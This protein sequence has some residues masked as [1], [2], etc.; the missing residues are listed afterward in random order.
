M[1]PNTKKRMPAQPSTRGVVWLCIVAMVLASLAMFLF[2]NREVL[3]SS[4]F[5]SATPLSNVSASAS[6]GSGG[7]YVISEEK[8]RIEAFDAEGRRLFQI[9][10]DPQSGAAPSI[11]TELA[12]DGEGRLY[13]LDTQLDE[14]GLY[15]ISEHIL[16]Y[17]K[18]GKLER[19]LFEWKGDRKSKRIGQIKALQVNGDELSFF[20]SGTS[21]VE[22]KRMML[23]TGKWDQPFAF[24]LPPDRYISEIAGHEPGQIY[25]AT[26]RGAIYRVG[27]DGQSTKLY[28]TTVMSSTRKNF[29]ERLKLGERDSVTFI[30]R[31][32]NTVTRLR[33]SAHQPLETLA[34]AEISAAGELADY[35]I[36][37]QAGIYVLA[38]RLVEAT[39][40]GDPVR[41]V[42]QIKFNGQ[43]RLHHW[44]VWAAA[45]AAVA[46]V[47]LALRLTYVHVMRRRISFFLK[48]MVAFVPLIAIS[49]VLLSN[50][51]YQSFSAKM[52]EEMQREL[53]VLAQSGKYIIDGDQLE[54]LT[55]PND[56]MNY[57]YLQI[58][59][60]MNILFEGENSENRRGLYSTVYKYEDGKL[61]I[62]TDDNDGINMFKPYELTPENLAVLEQ[63]QIRSNSTD[64]AE[65]QWTYALAPIYNSE[66]TVVGIFETG[67]DRNVLNQENGRIF[68]SVIRQ[69]ILITFLILLVFVVSSYFLLASLRKLRRSV[70]E[71][72]NGNWDVEVSIRSR[73]EVADLGEQ[74]NLM[75]RHIRQYIRDITDFSEASYRFV[76]QQVIKYLGKRGIL[77]VHLGDQVQQNMVVMVAKIRS[78]YDMTKRLTPKENFNFMNSFLS[79]FGPL[80][81][82]EEGLISSYL[83]AGFMSLF[84]SRTEDAIQ[85]AIAIR[86]ELI[87]YNGHRRKSGYPPVDLG[88]AIHKGA[89]MMGIIGEESR[90]ES[91]VISD[92]V[93]LTT[94]LE[95]ASEQL[96]ASILI[97]RTALETM[98]APERFQYRWLG[99]I[100][101]DSKELPLELYDIYEGDEETARLGKDKTKALFERGVALYQEGRFFDARETFVEVI[102]WNRQ[103]KAAKLYFYLCDEYYQQGTAADWNGTLAVS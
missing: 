100:Q 39:A 88:I 12:V 3:Q 46:L 64:D 78:F 82:K 87:V 47:A 8:Q 71:I 13:V 49:M 73:D 86:K 53:S 77:D 45:V 21:G 101:L 67:R 48:Q 74:F 59:E 5:Q 26:R 23:S 17:T 99:R 40:A 4:P 19:Q 22:Q 18:D 20:I 90:M 28:P 70:T 81:R 32:Q 76:P 103:D 102:K 41:T 97:T 24:T 85:S 1:K 63:G 94:R 57:D 83:G 61:Y 31:A 30:D 33:P 34:H 58:K 95:E 60:R 79:R 16:R 50:S 27:D 14:Y 7:R 89:L 25:Y 66:G 84:P 56:Y 9:N 15:V 10:K 65:G 69:I 11:Y 93:S 35:E 43:E 36:G 92:D 62:I 68:D 29:P 2:V 44:L 42:D 51:I 91:N 98:E 80:V 96:G 54:R 72:T 55:S 75:V 38:D 52:E 37:E 6:D